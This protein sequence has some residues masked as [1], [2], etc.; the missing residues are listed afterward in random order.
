[1]STS[2][3]LLLLV[4]LGI[5]IAVLASHFLEIFL[6]FALIFLFYAVPLLTVLALLVVAWRLVMSEGKK[7]EPLPQAKPTKVAKPDDHLEIE[8]ELNRLK[9]QI[10]QMNR[11]NKP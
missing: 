5:A 11:R 1:M 10:G 9:H 7:D 3:R 8:R 2:T 6:G 4:I